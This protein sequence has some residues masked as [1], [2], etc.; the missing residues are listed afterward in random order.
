VSENT[1]FR[2]VEKDR[3]PATQVDGQF[4][5]SPA[6]VYEWATSRGVPISGNL[7]EEQHVP[8]HVPPLTQALRVGGVVAG[9]RG[10]DKHAVMTA[11]VEKLQLPPHVDRSVILQM[12]LAREK[13]GSTGI[14]EGFAFP[15]VR[16]P[17]VLRV[18]QPQVTLFLL[19][20]P[21]EFGAVDHLPVHTLFLAVTPTI[22]THLVI[23]S[24][25]GTVLKDPAVRAAIAGRE[26]P[27]RIFAAIEHAERKLNGH[28]VPD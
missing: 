1:V 4:R 27:D 16:D 5:F 18:Q 17:I 25:L 3:L 21:I 2:W 24:R 15:H 13:L 10:D 6:A 28:Q 20:H 26:A 8:H 22:K 14:G 7:F 12:L 9:L 11:A 23:L 19:E